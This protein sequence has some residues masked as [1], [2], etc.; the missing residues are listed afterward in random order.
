MSSA[1]HRIHPTPIGNLTLVFA[2]GA[3]TALVLPGARHVPEPGELAPDAGSDV[4]AQ[5][6]EWFAGTR[7]A[8]DLRIALQGTPFQRRVWA[9]LQRIPYGATTTYGA[10]AA[11]LGKPGA[12]R[13]VGAAAGRNPVPIIVP[14]HRLVGTTS[15]TGYAGGL[16]TKAALLAH[17][18]HVVATR[19]GIPQPG[20][21]AVTAVSC[22]VAK[23]TRLK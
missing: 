8:F 7:T 10:L 4:V 18:A 17:E 6:D 21:G 15:L 13:A 23:P 3:L 19:A 16:A 11:A 2:D 12:A 9:E 14:C 1:R 5:L 22:Q 20:S